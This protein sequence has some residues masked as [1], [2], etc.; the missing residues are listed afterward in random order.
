MIKVNKFSEGQRIEE[1]FRV[2]KTPEMIVKLMNVIARKAKISGVIVSPVPDHYSNKY[3]SFVGFFV[4]YNREDILRFNFQRTGSSDQFYSIDIYDI[5]KMIPIKTIDLLGYNVVDVVEYVADVLSGEFE[6]YAEGYDRS[7]GQRKLSEAITYLQAVTMWFGENPEIE[8]SIRNLIDSRPTPTKL[9]EGLERVRPSFEAFLPRT[10]VRLSRNAENAFKLN[11]KKHFENDGANASAIPS[12]QVIPGVAENLLAATPQQETAYDAFFEN[13]HIIKFKILRVYCQ[14]I[15]KNNPA[16]KSIYIYGDG[17]IGKS[18]WVDRILTP[19]PNTK[20]I[21]GKVTGYTGLVKALYNNRE[22]KIVIFDDVITDTDM[23]N[24]NIQ[25][26]LKAALDPDPPR[27][28]T[29]L[30]ASTNE[31]YVERGKFYL[32]EADYAEFSNF[33]KE[34]L[35]EELELTDLTDPIYQDTPDEFNYNS[36]TVFITN[37]KKVPQP[38][39]DRCW[40]LQMEFNNEQILDLIRDSLIDCLP[41]AE[42]SILLEAYE[43]VDR[44]ITL[45]KA[46]EFLSGLSQNNMIPRKL[47]FRVFNRVVAI[48]SLGFKDD[49]I[50]KAAIRIELGN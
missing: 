10:G 24:Q 25:V 34:K 4:R 50:M 14:Q 35:N 21:S 48:M 49:D 23:K 32:N 31:S 2:S 38:V 43:A 39:E 26:I 13:E 5:K 46:H 40:I 16:F 17:G 9:A 7:N 11:V 8:V 22:G 33:K 27:L 47:S 45:K 20:N 1:G 36:S 37:Y 15:A 29:I 42:E 12:I 30:K 6:T 41:E 3:G 44:D 19:L 18:Y 28:I